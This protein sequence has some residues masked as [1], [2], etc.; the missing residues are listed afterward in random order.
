MKLFMED[1]KAINFDVSVGGKRVF[2]ALD[3]ILDGHEVEKARRCHHRRE[4]THPRHQREAS[5][6][7]MYT[8]LENAGKQKA[9]LTSNN[10]YKLATHYT[11]KKRS[12]A[13]KLTK[14]R[15]RAG[16]YGALHFL[17]RVSFLRGYSHETGKRKSS[18]Q[19]KWKLQKKISLS[20]LVPPSS[21]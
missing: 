3:R 2:W 5:T 4:A 1:Y 7:A 14:V 9:F 15:L 18:N 11:T 12:Q 13:L 8:V 19:T 17:L 10:L 21:C 20:S 6:S 16:K